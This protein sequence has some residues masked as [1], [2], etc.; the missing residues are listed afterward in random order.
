MLL[1][2][3]P[4]V[5]LVLAL[6]LSCQAAGPDSPGALLHVQLRTRVQPFKGSEAWDEV[7]LRKDLPSAGS[8]ETPIVSLAPAVGNAIFDAS[9]VRHRSMPMVSGA[10]KQPALSESAR[11][12][13]I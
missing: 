2:S 11:G 13:R 9:G 12:A 4:A 8:G 10:Q 6:S 7:V 5:V 1:K 3:G